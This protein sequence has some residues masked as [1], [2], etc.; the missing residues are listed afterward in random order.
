[1]S[2]STSN[3]AAMIAD[4]IRC[5]AYLQALE[6]AIEPGCTV[7]DIGT[8]TGYFALQA[9]RLGAGTVYA[10]DYNP[11][12]RVA[13]ELVQLNA[14][15]DRIQ[16]I[17]DYST[18][19][20]LPKQADVIVSDIRGRLP[21]INGHIEAI[22]DARQRHLA[23]GGV[24]IPLRDRIYA[25]LVTC[26]E[27][28]TR[29]LCPW[30]AFPGEW[31]MTPWTWPM[32]NSMM[33]PD[34]GSDALVSDTAEVACWDYGTIKSPTLDGEVALTVQ[35]TGDCHGVLVWFDASLTDT[36]GFGGLDAVANDMVYGSLFFPWPKPLRLATG[37]T[38]GVRLRANLVSGEYVW[39]WQSELPPDG[40]GRRPR[41]E[42]STLFS[43]PIN[44]AQV[45]A[46]APDSAPGLTGEGLRSLFIL[47]Q[48]RAGATV[49]QAAVALQ[50]EYP[51]PS[52]TAQDVLHETQRVLRKFWL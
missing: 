41:F 49:K 36:I 7:L 31:D 35:K 28:Y 48:I 44:L 43:E 47:S 37:D 5:Q 33:P 24:Q 30:T 29:R 12:V 38:V 45:R 10:V 16:V 42:Q 20:T 6:E 18:R 2:Y 8:G 3:Y 50:A 39:T 46:L 34:F 21:V 27:Y 23:P 14:L 17:E 52:R 1:M 25:G 22:V 11:A 19:I 15:D 51:D 40:A 13:Q 4:K 9:C 26:P 32:A